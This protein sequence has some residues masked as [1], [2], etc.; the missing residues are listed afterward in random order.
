MWY[1]C[2]FVWA[3]CRRVCVCEAYLAARFSVMAQNF[4]SNWVKEDIKVGR[5]WGL[6]GVLVN[7]W[8]FSFNLI[9]HTMEVLVEM[10]QPCA[11]SL[12]CSPQ[13][14]RLTTPSARLLSN[15]RCTLC[16]MTPVAAATPRVLT[17]RSSGAFQPITRVL[18]RSE[19]EERENVSRVSVWPDS[20][21]HTSLCSA[22]KPEQK[23][24]SSTDT[25]S[26]N[27]T[28]PENKIRLENCVKY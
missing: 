15:S 1:V 18:R 3:I 12:D 6:F 25:R 20:D 22:A 14:K 17:G 4:L 23:Q 11:N 24:L 13:T 19:S 26:Q 16:L 27:S 9:G 21:T 7:N 8:S 10:V 5:R 28:R 2:L